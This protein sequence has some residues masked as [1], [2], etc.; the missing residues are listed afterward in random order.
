MS[1]SA[2]D[3]SADSNT[4]MELSSTAQLLIFIRGVTQDF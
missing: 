1:L 2:L 4:L 3:E